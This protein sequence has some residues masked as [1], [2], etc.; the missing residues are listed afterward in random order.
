MTE[1][2]FRAATE[3]DADRI[4]QLIE[5]AKT[6]MRNKGRQQW[7]KQYPARMHI[8]N[9]IASGNGYVLCTTDNDVAVAYGAILF[10]GEPAYDDIVGSWLTE[11]RAPYVVLHRLAVA[12]EMRRQGVATRFFHEVERLGASKGV[13]SFR[14]DTNYDNDY[15][16]RILSKLG[17]SYCGEIKYQQGSRQAFER[18]LSSFGRE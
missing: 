10:T 16:L 7:S 17:F 4:M 2:S 5:Q 11:K 13:S 18:V 12:E 3:S 14:V 9:D 1:F 8:D 6:L 15:M